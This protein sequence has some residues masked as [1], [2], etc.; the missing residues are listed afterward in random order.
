ME[1][2]SG[3]GATGMG[4]R[5]GEMDRRIKGQICMKMP[6]QARDMGQS[7]KVFVTKPEAMT[8]IPRTHMME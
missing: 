1:Y 3:V 5:Q 6:W 7:I 8:L 4:R 2:K